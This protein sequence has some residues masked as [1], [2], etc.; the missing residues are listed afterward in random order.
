MTT[1]R[2]KSSV[3]N[4]LIFGLCLIVTV[5]GRFRCHNRCSGHGYCSDYDNICYCEDGYQGLDCSQSKMYII[6]YLL[7]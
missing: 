4:R 1:L 2:V 6:F 5:Y 3:L 7:K